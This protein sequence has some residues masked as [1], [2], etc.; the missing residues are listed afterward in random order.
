MLHLIILAIIIFISIY[1][2]LKTL[3]EPVK[4]YRFD[5]LKI[6]TYRGHIVAIIAYD[7]NQEYVIYPRYMQDTYQ[8]WFK[9][10]EIE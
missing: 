3:Q 9:N 6:I 4:E 1:L 10:G 5:N 7:S 2:L 8:T